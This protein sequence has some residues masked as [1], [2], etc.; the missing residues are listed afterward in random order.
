MSGA[1]S[2]AAHE[3]A[4]RL[5]REAKRRRTG[6]CADCGTVTR[7]G[8][9][10]GVAV[11]VRCPSCSA[12]KNAAENKRGKG[13]L[14]S[15]V[16]AELQ[17]GPMTYSEIRDMLRLPN[18]RMGPLLVRLLRYGLIERPRRGLYQLPADRLENP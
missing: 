17:H 2:Q 1:R 7:Y 9:R 6:T 12:Q 11:S 15:R 4:R 13:P 5:S 8:G 18:T 16:L 3:N 10:A 14:N